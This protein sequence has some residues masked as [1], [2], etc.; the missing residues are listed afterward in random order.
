MYYLVVFIISIVFYDIYK[1]F[2]SID[3]DRL[4]ED[5]YYN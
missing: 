4:L 2:N 3:R 5:K 1:E